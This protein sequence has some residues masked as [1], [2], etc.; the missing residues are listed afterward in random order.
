MADG[1]VHW[2]TIGGAVLTF[3]LILG[4]PLG[5]VIALAFRRRWA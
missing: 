2:V 3:L 4:I 5:L 1:G